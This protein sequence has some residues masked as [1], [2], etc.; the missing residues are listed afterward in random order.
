MRKD[1]QNCLERNSSKPLYVQLK[2][3]IQEQIEN[4][5]WQA[6]QMIPSENELASTYG[7]SRMTARSVISQLVHE[8][9]LYR[10]QGK[11]TFVCESK[12]EMA[13]L[14]YAGVRGQLEK[15]GYKVETK[16]LEMSR[17]PCA[18][19]V[20]QRLALVPG[21]LVFDIK[22]LRIANGLPISYH[23]SF[24][25][26]SLCDNL[27]QFDL[28]NEQLCEIMSIYYGLNRTRSVETLETY[29]ADERQAAILEVDYGFPLLLLQDLIVS[30]GGQAF[31]YSRVYFRGD[32]VILRFEHGEDR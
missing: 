2:G 9:F 4:G 5:E 13:S 27:E 30:G 14:S 26:V 11:G 12:I 24:V 16:L 23:H 20:S 3:I 19:I 6:N 18:G 17:A 22:R 31:E 25:P 15:K 8:G 29:L 1:F 7:I 10:V 32:K 28:Q 21:S